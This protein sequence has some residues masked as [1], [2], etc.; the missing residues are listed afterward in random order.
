MLVTYRSP[1]NPIVMADGEDRPPF[2]AR[3]SSTRGPSKLPSCGEYRRTG[4][5]LGR[6]PG[7]QRP[8]RRL[9]LGTLT[10]QGHRATQQNT[11]RQR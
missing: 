10:A 7:I 1:S 11:A 5:W 4:W 6:S 9:A 2:V 8:Q 3:L